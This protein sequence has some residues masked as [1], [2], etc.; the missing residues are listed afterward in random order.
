MEGK[1]LW[2]AALCLEKSAPS[3]NFGKSIDKKDEKFHLITWDN[4]I[5]LN[6]LPMGTCPSENTKTKN[7]YF[8]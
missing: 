5:S 3:R 2:R 8:L 6:H 7:L 1:N 4:E